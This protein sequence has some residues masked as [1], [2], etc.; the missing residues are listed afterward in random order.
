MNRDFYEKLMTDLTQL[1][2]EAYKQES[3]LTGQLVKNNSFEKW[4]LFKFG[5]GLKVSIYSY[6][7]KSFVGPIQNI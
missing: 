5:I 4:D 1:H 7:E 6:I 2:R 3:T